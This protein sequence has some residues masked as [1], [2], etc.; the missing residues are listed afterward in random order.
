ML[1]LA[2]AACGTEKDEQPK[3]KVES[4]AS[5]SEEKVIDK[6]KNDEKQDGPVAADIY[7]KAI[8][9][10]SE[11]NSMHITMDVYNN[12]AVPK[13]DFSSDTTMKTT[14]DLIMEPFALYQVADTTVGDEEMYLEWY[15]TEDVL[16]MYEPSADLWI[17]MPAED[18][19]ELVVDMTER[20]DQFL[21][22]EMFEKSADDFTVE[23]T[24]SAYTVKLKAS[25]KEFNHIIEEL[26][27]EDMRAEF[28]EDEDVEIGDI[29]VKNIAIEFSIAKDTFFTNGFN[30]ELEV[31]LKVDGVKMIITQKT[32]TDVS[33]LNE[34]EK[35]EIPQEV[36]DNAY[37]Y[38]EL[39]F[40]E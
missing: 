22:L 36:I 4:E 26:V 14:L 32:K 27:V 35:I 25:G 37:T 30:L 6:K 8:A 18:R 31:S 24:D 34:I 17:D 28:D 7:K 23:E 39:E 21:F 20:V 13:R 19:D 10:I 38:D 5:S 11:Q 9:A 33:K 1:V 12:V 40:E 3:N 2:L 15:G 16:Y 29:N